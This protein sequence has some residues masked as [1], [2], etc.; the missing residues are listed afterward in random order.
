MHNFVLRPVQLSDTNQ[1]IELV[2]SMRVGIASLPNDA[3]ILR[4]KIKASMNAFNPSENKTGHEHYLFVLEDVESGNFAGIC[5]LY[6]HCGSKSTLFAYELEN[7]YFH[8]KPM[9]ISK[10]VDVLRFKEIKQS[11]SEV[12][13]LYLKPEYRQGGLGK[14]LSLGRYLFIQA[15]PDWFQEEIMA[16]L[17][18]YR[19]EQ[20]LSPFFETIG[21]VFFD[22]SL[23]TVDS[24]KSLGHKKFIRALMPKHPLYVPLLKEEVIKTLGKVYTKTE[25]ALH[26]LK[27]Q[28]FKETKWLDIFDAGPYLVAKQKDIKT[29]K[30]HK[31]AKITKSLADSDIFS[32]LISNKR[33]DYRACR[34]DVVE[35]TNN[36]V[37]LSNSTMKLLDVKIGDTITYSPM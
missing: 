24:M 26:L 2:A 21:S 12:C 13:S 32:H 18:G 35:Y 4:K 23:R 14:L 33:A 20:E 16:L 37:G 3:S 30:E 7:E 29:I 6:A 15:F 1:V 19:N 9:K 34:G 17:R 36:E 25:P 11:P 10:Q 8:Y 27:E 28:G 22:G 5:G 31:K